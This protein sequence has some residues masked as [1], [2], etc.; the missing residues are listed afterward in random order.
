MS[1]TIYTF[2]GVT[3]LDMPAA[4]VLGPA[5]RADLKS[6]VILGYRQDGSEYFASSVADGGTVIWLMESLKAQLLRPPAD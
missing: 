1:A 6:V 4:T 2:N 5:L 3:Q